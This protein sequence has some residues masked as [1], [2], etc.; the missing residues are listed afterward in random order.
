MT[1]VEI[2][3]S[4]SELTFRQRWSHYFAL[5]FTVIGFGI[6]LNLRESTLSAVTT[7]ANPQ[8]GIVAAYPRGWLLDESSADYIF[9][10]RDMT[11]NGFSTTLQV[12]A[13]PV[14][15]A[16]SARNIFDSLTLSRAQVLAAYNVISEDI[17]Q[18]P[19][20]T[21]TSSMTYSYVN[22]QVN[23]FLQNIPVVVQGIDILVIARGQAIIISFLEESS[24]FAENLI[25]L[26][27][28]LRRLEF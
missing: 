25:V 26:E 17:F 23:P 20:G 1:I 14:S 15:A 21:D 8:A 22:T 9:R 12:A 16:T 10:V 7:Y 19:D 28:F 5:I 13:Q 18:L 11:A 24:R 27:R 3:A 4:S 2:G 6:G